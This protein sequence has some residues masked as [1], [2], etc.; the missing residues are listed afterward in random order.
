MDIISLSGI[1]ILA[2]ALCVVVRQLSPESA[3]GLRTACSVGM[4]AAAVALLAPSIETM[5]AL[6]EKA[7]IDAS[8]AAVLIKALAVCYITQLA[9]DCCRDAGESAIAS[10]L[11]LAGKAAV[12]VISLP[13]FTELAEIVTDLL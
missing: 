10:K 9:A 5:T 2:A 3:F 7:G 8:F 11:E 4:L 1:A 6:T 12:T 13:V